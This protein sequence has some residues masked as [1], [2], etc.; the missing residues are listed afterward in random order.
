MGLAGPGSLCFPTPHAWH[1]TRPQAGA[2]ETAA[3]LTRIEAGAL[4]ESGL[5]NQGLAVQCPN[6]YTHSAAALLMG[7]GP[8]PTLPLIGTS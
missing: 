7:S 6:I 5:A 3:E 8:H 2:Q 1:A 4:G